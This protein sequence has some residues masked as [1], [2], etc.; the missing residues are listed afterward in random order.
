MLDASNILAHWYDAPEWKAIDEQGVRQFV[1]D[2]DDPWADAF[3]LE[4]G[5]YPDAEDIGIDYGE[6]LSQATMSM[7]CRLDKAK[8]I[9][10][11]VPNIQAS[12]I[13]P[14]TDFTAITRCSPDGTMQG[15]SS[16]RR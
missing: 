14:A 15:S 16:G 7:D 5:A 2:D 1:W 10:M 12:A 11:D 3:L 9:P 4:H 8:P 6:I 13:S